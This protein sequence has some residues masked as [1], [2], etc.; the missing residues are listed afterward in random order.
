[1]NN[2]NINEPEIIGANTEG[3]QLYETN[4]LHCQ[5]TNTIWYE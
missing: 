2:K 3:D 1:M 4:S 5:N